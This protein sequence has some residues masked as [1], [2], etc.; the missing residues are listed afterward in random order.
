MLQNFVNWL[1]HGLFRLS[2]D[3]QFGS[4]LNFFFYET[5]KILILLFIISTIMGVI[6]AYFPIEKLRKFLTTR[7]LYG[8]QYLFAALF[9]AITPFCSCSSVPL[10]IGFVKGGIPLGVTLSFLITSPMVNE[11]AV[12][13]FLGT[14]G[15]KVTLI[16]TISGILLGT[17]GGFLLEKLHLD[18]Y[19]TDWVKN[20]QMISSTKEQTEWDKANLSFWHHLPTIIKDSWKVVKGVLL[21]VVI[22]I[23]IGAAMHGYIPEGFFAKY[24]SKD[25]W[26]AV[27]LSVIL[28]VPMY[29]NAAGVVPIIQVF[30][31]KGIP[32]GT[33]IAFMM[34][35]VGLSLPE[36][37]L[38][39]K[40]MTWRLI[41]IY[42]GVVSLMFI[43]SGYLFNW[44]M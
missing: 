6:N 12:A 44:I 24:M 26:Y 15:L 43:F 16:Y 21:Y 28:A 34:G 7:K 27:P 29:A 1:V 38:L 13:M 37:T 40:V 10:F 18:K 33:A 30:V 23:S 11:V 5:I 20:I 8:L 2:V 3:S 35:V 42:F 4:A 14:F 17:I 22:G 32:I 25:N 9:G 31:A 39:K 19:L 36:A 41:G